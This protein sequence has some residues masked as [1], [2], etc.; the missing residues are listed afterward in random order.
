MGLWDQGNRVD[1]VQVGISLVGLVS[2]VAALVLAV[3]IGT[4]DAFTPEGRRQ[5]RLWL[6]GLLVWIALLMAL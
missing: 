3:R 4:R 5:A 1:W 2:F 6:V